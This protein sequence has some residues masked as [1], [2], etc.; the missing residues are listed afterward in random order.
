ME[1]E[2][3]IAL[4]LVIT[5]H[6]ERLWQFADA[7]R[8]DNVLPGRISLSAMEAMNAA[9]GLDKE[10]GIYVGSMSERLRGGVAGGPRD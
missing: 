9:F 4:V 10:P 5:L 1:P 3:A 2:R 6:I 7:H 8:N